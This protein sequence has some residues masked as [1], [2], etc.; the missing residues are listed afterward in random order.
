VINRADLSPRFN[1][2]DKEGWLLK[3]TAELQHRQP[4]IVRQQQVDSQKMSQDVADEAMA[5]A[6]AGT[7]DQ[8]IAQAPIM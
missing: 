4:A 6:T 7:T 5:D 3:A 1:I 2:K 8:T